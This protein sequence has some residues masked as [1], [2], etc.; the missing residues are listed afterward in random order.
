M[1]L[2]RHGESEYNAACGAPGSSWEEPCIFDAALTARGVAQA[3]AAGV[4]LAATLAGG[5]GASGVLWVASPLTRALHTATLARTA[6]RDAAPAEW[7]LPL[8]PRRWLEVCPLAAEH[9][10]TSGDVGRPPALLAADFPEL[11]DSGAFEAL[12]ELWWFC[13]PA[14]PNCAE[15]QLLGCSEPRKAMLQRIGAFRKWLLNR[16][17]KEMVV[18]GHSTFFKYLLQGEGVSEKRCVSDAGSALLL[19]ALCRLR[20]CELYSLTI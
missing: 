16:P 17:E 11:A 20:N 10:M 14:K 15:R 1:H 9:M 2:L 6:L 19:T 4:A 12:P 8:P 3:R 18:V 7:P 5:V 13:P